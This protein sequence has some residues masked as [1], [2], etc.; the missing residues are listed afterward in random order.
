MLDQLVAN[1]P[2]VRTVAERICPRHRRGRAKRGDH[3]SLFRPKAVEEGRVA[4]P[5]LASDVD[6]RH[7]GASREKAAPCCVHDLL[8]GD[9]AR[10]SHHASRGLDS[11]L[12]EFISF[13]T[14][15]IA[16]DNLGTVGDPAMEYTIMTA[17]STLFSPY[18]LGSLTLSNR[19]V[20]SP[21]TRSRAIGNVPNE[22]MAKYY[23]QR[24]EAG[25]IITEGTSPSPDGLGYP[26]IPGLFNAAQVAGWRIVTDA[27][28]AA[29]SRIYVQL[30][31]TGR[32]GHPDNLPAGGR[33][34]GPSA[35][36]W[37]STIY[38]DGKGP[39][40]VPTAVAMTADDIERAIEEHARSAELAIEAGFDGVE[41][42]GANGYLIEQFLNTASNHR[43]DEWGGTVN[44]RIRFAVEVARRAASRI[45][46]ERLGIR[47][48][49][50]SAAGGL[51]SADDQVET[52][53]ETLAG[54]L[55]RLGLAYIHIVDHSALGM[56]PVPWSVK[57]KIRNAFKQ[58]V[59]LSGGYDVERANADLDAGRGDLVAFGRPF[60]SNPRLVTRLRGGL[61]LAGADFATFYT[62][63][64]AGY[65][66]YAEAPAAE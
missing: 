29:G 30:M 44:N 4:H 15:T 65:T 19:V 62:P 7:S 39:Q 37:E 8:V 53:H 23:V 26:R 64:E 47:V 34:V 5:E 42:H 45:G 46:A 58:T 43:Q 10:S 33:V 11:S 25:L 60:I 63:G 49:P 61:P 56:P 24:S 66:D 50:Y 14:E 16:S 52:L 32:V 41:L 27:V 17:A 6:S 57:E 55:D 18:T 13:G 40:A 59:I 2:I 54:E 21:M 1:R 38:V 22:L 20:M 12:A 28:H 3:Q 51:T 9:F 31:H 36:P 35:L 48:S